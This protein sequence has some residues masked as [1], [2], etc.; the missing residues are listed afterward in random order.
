[1]RA[2]YVN[3]PDA[4]QFKVVTYDSGAVE[5]SGFTGFSS[6][7]A[8]QGS[9]E[10]RGPRASTVSAEERFASSVGRS[11]ALCRARVM[12]LASDSMLTLTKRGKFADIQEAW[13]AFAFFSRLMKRR[14]G[15]RW[16]YV[17]VPELHADGETWHMHV[18]IKGFFWVGTLRRFWYRAL[19]GAGDEA[20]VNT[21][22]NVD[23]KFFK[24]RA[25]ITASGAVASYV[26]KYVGKGLRGFDRHRR[27][28]AASAGLHPVSI[29]KWHALEFWGF[30]DAAVAVQRFLCGLGCDARG[31]AWFFSRGR[32][33]GF[34]LSTCRS[35]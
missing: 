20:G 2:G 32:L 4:W 8:K 5:V 11:R 30:Q 19:G 23:V 27:V 14:Y 13:T 22:G 29:E 28:F 17:A 21:P 10:P 24:P 7:R 18:A 12:A 15:D 1:M 34:R 25:R 33:A 16:R 6:I 9:S 3:E 31:S 35:D 26:A